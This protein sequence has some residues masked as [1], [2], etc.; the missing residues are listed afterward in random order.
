MG[1]GPSMWEV[2][3]ARDVGSSSK[4]GEGG[5]GTSTDTQNGGKGWDPLSRGPSKLRGARMSSS[6]K[7]PAKAWH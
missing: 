7:G 6:G 3:E 4:H 1:D 5:T 2:K